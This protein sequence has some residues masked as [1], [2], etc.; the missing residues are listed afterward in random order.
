MKRLDA[1]DQIG[2]YFRKEKRM[3]LVVTVTGILYNVG[4]VA[5]P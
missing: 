1:T 5:G 2:Y 3:L 4:M